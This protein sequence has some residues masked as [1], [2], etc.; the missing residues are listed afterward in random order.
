[1]A[2]VSLFTIEDKHIRNP[3]SFADESLPRVDQINFRVV[4]GKIYCQ[5]DDEELEQGTTAIITRCCRT[6]FISSEFAKKALV[7]KKML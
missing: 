1:M 7:K 2:S 6:V 4:D 5:I 3:E